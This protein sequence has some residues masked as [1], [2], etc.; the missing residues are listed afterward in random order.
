M[1]L[2]CINYE[3][4]NLEVNVSNSKITELRKDLM[5]CLNIKPA[6]SYYKSDV[7]IQIDSPQMSYKARHIGHIHGSS[8]SICSID[9]KAIYD[10]N[11]R[12]VHFNKIIGT[13]I[14][15]RVSVSR[16]KI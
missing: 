4:S 5:R 14:L 16:R 6:D 9:L 8:R 12:S 7:K 15:T 13:P 11:A 2:K 10:L 3:K 1:F